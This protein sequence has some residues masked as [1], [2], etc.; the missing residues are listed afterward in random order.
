MAGDGLIEQV[1][2]IRAHA[3]TKTYPPPPWYGMPPPSLPNMACRHLQPSRPC[4]NQIGG[5]Q[6][7][8]V[9]MWVGATAHASDGVALGGTQWHSVALS[10]TQ[11]Q[12]VAHP[13]E[14]GGKPSPGRSRSRSRPSETDGK[15]IAHAL[16]ARVASGHVGEV[17]VHE[18]VDA[19]GVQ[20][21]AVEL[22][23]DCYLIAS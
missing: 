23:C 10:G 2:A 14:D 3:R 19:G 21:L 7:R 6:I 4:T 20:R 15:R 8:Q 22:A 1:M 5:Y 18:H 11:W 13:V 12:S 9:A 16:R 17:R